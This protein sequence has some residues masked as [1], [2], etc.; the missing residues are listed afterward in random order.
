MRRWKKGLLL[1]AVAAALM[2]GL[3][4][5]AF[6]AVGN[7]NLMAV[8][9]TVLATTADNM[10]RTMGGA[11][12]VPYTMLS[13]LST[14]INLGVN[15]MYSTTRRTVLVTDG[16]Q[17]GVIF[18]TQANTA[19]DL[20][21]KPLSVRAM[22]RNTTV[23]VPID[24]LCEYFGT[25]TCTRIQSPYG[26]VIRV[27]NAAAIL[28][29][30]DFID[31]ASMNLASALRRYLDS[32][33]LGEGVDPIPSGGAEVS[34]PPS[35]AELYLACRWGAEA[36]ECAQLMEGRDQRALFLFAPEE[37]AGQ[38]DLVRRLAGAGHTLGLVLDGESLE[39]CLGQAGEGRGLLAAAARYN[40]LVVS[41]P[42]LDEEGRGALA[43]EGYVIWSAT[44]LGEDYSTGAGLVRGLSTRRVN[45]VEVACASGG[46]A[47]LRGALNT[48]EDENCQVYQA[49]APAL[50]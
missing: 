40:A 34:D 27:T 39:D 20:N 47:F 9:D 36:R 28:S 15:A 31:A 17:R 18:D 49:T 37:I 33:G 44:A 10:P 48:M 42:N 29:D 11:L 13:Q 14:G 22:V 46:A 30:Q 6:G 38:D 5:P 3:L 32:G 43:E 21:G 23:F 16:G 8:N 4:A 1:A 2:L 19:Q 26:I 45:Y 7:V 25:I 35:G 12:Y 50:A 41:A 24:W